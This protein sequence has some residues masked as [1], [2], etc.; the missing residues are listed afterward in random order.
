MRSTML[1]LVGVAVVM[2]AGVLCPPSSVP[3]ASAAGPGLN[4]GGSSFAKL[5][6]DQWRAEVARK[7]YELGINYVAQG[8]SFGRNQYIIGALDFAASDIPFQAPELVELNKTARKDFV[9]VPVSA[10]GLGFMYN[11]IDTAGQQVTNLNLSPHSACRMFT[12]DTMKW[13]DPELQT[14]NPNLSLPDHRVG[15]IVRADGSGTSYVLSEFCISTSPDVWS[16]FQA[17]E[18]NNSSAVP[19]LAAGEPISNWPTNRFGS[20]VAADGV[21]AAVAD[22]SGLY[23]IT[24][25]EAGFAKVRG[26]PNASML[27]AAGQFTQPTEGAVSIALGYATGRPNGTF[28]LDFQGADP[29]AY[30]PST[31]SY[32]IAQ[33]TG[34]D[35]AK[36]E[37]LARFLCYS[38]TKGQR[39][40][41]TEALGYARLS[42]PLIELG[43][44]AIAQIPGAPP[45]DQCKVES[46]PPPPASGGGA[47]GGGA[48]GGGATGGGATGGGATGGGATGAD[49]T[50]SGA[51][52]GAASAGTTGNA[53][54]GNGSS[55]TGV[56]GGG[57]TSTSLAPTGIGVSTDS[58]A[59]PNSAL[60]CTDADTG[61]PA[62]CST[63]GE[64]AAS[65]QVAGQTQ[66]AS[67]A[68]ALTPKNPTVVES[69]G[70]PTT[71]QILWWLLQG[72]SICALGFALAGMRSRL[73]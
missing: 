12:D 25:N 3:R 6:I 38:I 42:A 7:P 68:T 63:V 26:F 28:Q 73:V 15:A 27:N 55:G 17:A 71:T 57:V 47:T 11:L 1:R 13:N 9:Y 35:P 61:L 43:K 65:Q 58:G 46:A 16:A 33:T 10:G 21:A 34:F 69:S 49:A 59:D 8:S 14:L 66:G 32:V 45:W 53:A 51:T 64:G 40:D 24:Y 18:L 31:Y 22:A 70:T 52:G 19:E 39:V 44:T 48:T 56:A 67:A 30:F 23:G 29:A 37:V 5:E 41:L 72:A 54:A 62:D 50:A 2:L 4:G 20:A 36:G 60:V